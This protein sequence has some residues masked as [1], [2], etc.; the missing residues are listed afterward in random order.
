MRPQRLKRHAVSCCVMV[1]VLGATIDTRSAQAAVCSASAF[2]CPPIG[3]CVVTGGWSIGSNCT[4]D[5]GAR[6]VEISGTWTADVL[7]GSYEIRARDL[8]LNGGKLRSLG[9]STNPG[10]EIG[11]VL[12]GTFK[13]KGSG[14][15]VD[16]SGNGGGGLIRVIAAAIDL[17]TGTI[18]ADGGSDQNC[19]DGGSI[20]LEA[21]DGAL[22]SAINVKSTTGGNDCG[23]GSIA[24]TGESISVSGDVDAHGGGWASF[25]AITL[26]ATATNV[27]VWSAAELN[28]DGIGQ[29]DGVG[30]DGG[31]IRI[32]APLGSI[33]A[34][35]VLGNGSREVPIRRRRW[36]RIGGRSEHHKFVPRDD[37]RAVRMDSVGS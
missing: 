11:V 20:G 23:G 14:P 26:T 12:G 32:S 25:E 8:T 16:T 9:N 22:T 30:A 28:A 35:G 17:Q 4:I 5:F 1:L 24:M 7:S 15:T 6:D 31:Q 2:P 18:R 19:G 36:P 37:P 10:G 34:G 21:Y 29:P 3:T 27:T 13:T 33:S